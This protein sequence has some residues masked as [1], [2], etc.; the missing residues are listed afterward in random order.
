MG[1]EEIYTITVTNQ[2]TAD[3]NNIR[4]ECTLPPEMDF[5]SADGP[6]K[7]KVDGKV[8]TF[9][10]LPSLAPKA[11]AVYR[12][13]VKGNKPADVRFKTVLTSDMLTSP[14]QETESTHVY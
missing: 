6:T 12:V 8:V 4:I 3:D 10:P 14:V 13:V 1:A 5:V 7:S 11:K 9:E 2:G